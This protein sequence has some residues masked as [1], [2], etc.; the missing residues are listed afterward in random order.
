MKKLGCSFLLALAFGAT[1]PAHAQFYLPPQCDI[2]TKHFL[3]N[4]AQL[5]VKAASETSDEAQRDQALQDAD[6][7]LQDAV[8]RGEVGE[9]GVWYF[10]ARTYGMMGDFRGADSAFAKVESMMPE[11]V[12]DTD[13]HRNMFWV[14]VYNQA[15]ASI[16]ASDMTGAIPTLTKAND[17]YHKEPFVPYYLGSVYAQESAPDS[18][19]KYFKQAVEQMGPAPDSTYE[20]SRDL[21]V[22]NIARLYHQQENWDSALVW[23]EAYR[24]IKPNDRDAMLGL[25]YSYESNGD[26]ARSLQVYEEIVNNSTDATSNDLFSIG[27][28]LFN[29]EAFA[30]AAKAFE[31]GLAKNPYHRDGIYNLGQSYFAIASPVNTGDEDAPEPT[32]EEMATRTRAAEDMLNAARRLVEVD[33]SNRDALMMLAQGWQLAGDDDSTI[34]AF[35]LIDALDYDVLFT[36][37]NEMEG[38]FE[39]AGAIE[40]LRE[41]E[42]T[43]PAVTFE[44]V[45]AEG[46]VIGTEMFAGAT[47]EPLGRTEF[48]FSATGDGIVA[49]RYSIPEATQ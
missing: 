15:V 27:V 1:A 32:A 46:T 5:Y 22:F 49:W 6:R 44:F 9:V 7:V 45:D 19:I 34:A 4:Q 36:E 12:D 2:D 10:L 42:L 14:P 17:I 43:I 26:T 20:D 35:E 11:C 41:E 31:A 25:A 18:A 24:E 13:T 16:Q 40:N 8:E 23:Y 28:S 30:I 29:A 39:L 37:F 33:P 3:V 21:S 47:L 38:G 48:R